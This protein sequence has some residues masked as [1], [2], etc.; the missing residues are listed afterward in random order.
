MFDG[1]LVGCVGHVVVLLSLSP[2]KEPPTNGWNGPNGQTDRHND[3]KSVRGINANKWK[4]KYFQRFCGLAPKRQQRK[5]FFFVFWVR[6]VLGRQPRV[7]GSFPLSWLVPLLAGV[8]FSVPVRRT[9]YS[10][11]RIPYPVSVVAAPATVS[12]RRAQLNI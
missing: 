5:P 10:A 6:A 1:I 11:S 9:G 8:P 7:D 12:C 2:Q 3:S 4:H